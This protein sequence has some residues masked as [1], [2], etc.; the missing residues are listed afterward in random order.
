MTAATRVASISAVSALVLAAVWFFWP[1]VLGGGTT[2][3]TTH[4]VSM[5]PGFS[6]G[7]LAVLRPADSYATGD[8]VAYRSPTLDTIV[9]HRIV[10]GDARGFVTQGDN[11]DWL[12]EDHPGQDD[13]L[14]SL[15]FSVPQG[16]K[17]LAALKS[18]AVI[19]LVGVAALLVLGSTRIPR[20]RQRRRSQ[21]RAAPSFSLSTRALARQVALGSAAVVALAAVA[22][23]ALL[24]LPST[25]T[26][27]RAVEVTQQGQY[28]YTGEAAVGTTYPTGAIATGDIVWTRLARELSVTF[29]NTVTGPGVAGVGG[30]L[31]LDVVVS[32]ADGWSAVVGSGAPV[33]L[34]EGVATASV[35]VDADAAM[36]LLGRHY[37][38][39]GGAGGSG[40]VTV[41]PVAETSGTVEGQP[42]TADAPPALAFSLDA[43]SLKPS[44]DLGTVLAPTAATAVQVEETA[45]RTFEVLSLSI[46]FYLAQ[47]VAG[48]VLLA[49]LLTFG[50]G[51]WIGRGIRGD[52]AEQFLVRHADRILPVAA[53]SPGPAVVDVSDVESL[54]RVA[55]RFDTVVL[56]MAGPEGDVFAVRDLD[57][58]YRFVVPGTPERRTGKPP[59]PVREPVNAMAPEPAVTPLRT[60]FA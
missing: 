43:T 50:A 58:T 18:P 2:Y 45:P 35:D 25:Q 33:E 1:A 27:V 31:H 54:H 59:V 38:E 17:A 13:I 56:H 28:T 14:G 48:G 24:V 42:F 44:G 57:M 26:D 9:M 46:P 41:T 29:T 52:V 10:S 32:A 12:D 7:D 30:S 37:A 60:R 15:F 4:G 23:G 6:T 8:V 55:E 22:C 16:G 53:F 20:G 21:G 3:V 51:A 40:T 34:V 49:A 11:N 47:K 39:I 5:E 19:A 36:S